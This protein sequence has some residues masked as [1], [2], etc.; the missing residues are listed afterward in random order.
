MGNAEEFMRVFHGS[1]KTDKMFDRAEAL[2][3][4]AKAIKGLKALDSEALELLYAEVKAERRERNRQKGVIKIERVF[5]LGNGRKRV[6]YAIDSTT[7]VKTFESQATYE[8]WLEE[9]A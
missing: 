6:T 9:N 4:A 5:S 8:A 7:Y 3:N 1:S 2:Q